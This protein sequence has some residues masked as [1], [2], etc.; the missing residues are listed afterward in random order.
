MLESYAHTGEERHD[1]PCTHLCLVSFHKACKAGR[2]STENSSCSNK[3]KNRQWPATASHFSEFCLACITNRT[4]S[5][6]HNSSRFLGAWGI[7][8][9]KMYG[10]SHTTASTMLADQFSLV[11]RGSSTSPPRTP[12]VVTVSRSRLLSVNLECSVPE[13]DWG[14]CGIASKVLNIS[15]APRRKLPVRAH[16]GEIGVVICKQLSEMTRTSLLGGIRVRVIARL[17]AP[18]GGEVTRVET[19]VP[20]P[21][22]PRP[23]QCLFRPRPPPCQCRSG[24]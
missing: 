17:G 23:C 9:P 6:I 11:P 10:K 4:L 16:V 24:F 20:A 5:G 12:C 2:R 21:P 18:A 1:H 7:R 13:K 3:A 19:R 14:T 15:P 22:R 8:G